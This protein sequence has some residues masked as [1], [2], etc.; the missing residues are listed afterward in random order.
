MKPLVLFVDDEPIIL[1][2]LKN[3]L[4]DKLKHDFQLEFTTDVEEA[5]EILEEFDFEE[6]PAT[7]ISDWIMPGI[8]GEDFLKEVHK[9]FP[10]VR[11][12]ILTGEADRALLKQAMEELDVFRCMKKP[13]DKE[14]VI[15]A[16][17]S[18]NHSF[19]TKKTIILCVDD[20]P[21][22]LRS[23]K[24]QLRDFFGPKFSVL[25]ETSGR[26][27]LE[28]LDELQSEN[29]LPHLIISDQLMPEMAGDEFL[30][31][32]K[33][34]YPEIVRILLTGEASRE[35][36]VSAINRAGL[37][38]FIS[39]PWNVEDLNLTVKEGIDA[40][41]KNNR[42]KEEKQR[43]LDLY[44]SLEERVTQRTRQLVLQKNTIE[45]QNISI[46]S[47]ITYAQRIQNA[48]LPSVDV[49]RENFNDSFVIYRP[50][51]VVSGDF[52]MF[53]KYTE[54][55]SY[56]ATIDCTGHGVPGAFLT[57]MGKFILDIIT[58][59]E[60]GTAPNE[61]L[62]I[63]NNKLILTLHG[64]ESEN[65][66]LISDGMDIALCKIDRQDQV[67]EF[68]GAYHCLY[69]ST[70]NSVNYIKGDRRGIGFSPFDNETEQKKFELNTINYNS[71]DKI[72][73]FSDGYNDQ[74]GGI[75]KKKYS[76]KRLFELLVSSNH[77]T[78]QEQ[79]QI[80]IKAHLDWKKDLLQT[81]DIVVIGL[82][83]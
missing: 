55:I 36:I 21:V 2:S 33:D 14:E 42:L 48:I 73:M 27:A 39:K 65:R 3:Q 44:L 68:S 57:I 76:R 16:I 81:D 60:K 43:V 13:W 20:E 78:L 53:W 30:S 7:V 22:I 47:S 37:Y 24:N 5:I 31:L 12:M 61:I 67:I 51:D 79:K 52:Y 10:K 50:K 28:L 26:E 34:N 63:L 19:N 8:S 56:V 41:N 62:T 32:V 74:F 49:I 6:T 4:K 45:E 83:L 77:R 11:K 15:K 66:E 82:E 80:L 17:K 25:T 29:T 35:N 59:K 54:S 69:H 58:S 40:F 38:R 9:N 18:P 46:K 70:N 1:G 23:L 72:F 75:F 71:G 64:D